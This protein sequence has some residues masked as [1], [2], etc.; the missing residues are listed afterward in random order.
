MHTGITATHTVPPPGL[1]VW[2]E[3]IV[4]LKSACLL[5]REG[6]RGVPLFFR[7]SACDPRIP[8]N[9]LLAECITWSERRLASYVTRCRVPVP[10]PPT[11]TVQH[12]RELSQRLESIHNTC[13]LANI[14]TASETAMLPQL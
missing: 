8:A 6:Y 9:T 7:K 13:L 12:T 2:K 1:A 11:N 10:Y 5:R 14:Q 4:I 3:N